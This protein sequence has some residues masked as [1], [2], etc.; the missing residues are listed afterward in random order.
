MTQ[1]KRDTDRKEQGHRRIVTG[2]QTDRDSDKRTGKGTETDMDMDTDTDMDNFNRQ[3]TK[4]KSIESVQ[5]FKK[6]QN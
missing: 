4:N 1:T 6:L 3:L 5:F 2:T